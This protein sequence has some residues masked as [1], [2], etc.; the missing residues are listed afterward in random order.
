MKG[1]DISEH[2]GYID[3]EKVKKAGIDFVIIRI[4]WIGNKENHTVDEYFEEYYKKAKENNL[5]IGFYVYS[6]VKSENAMNSAINWCKNKISG[7]TYEYPIF[8]DVEDEQISNLDKNL[9]T[10]LCRLFCNSFE[11]SGIYAS[12][13]WFKNKL[14]INELLNYKIWLAQWTSSNNHSA[15]F[16]VDLWQYSSNGAVEGINGR[17]DL[18][19]CLRCDNIEDITGGEN[20][21]MKIYQNGSTVENVYADTNLTNKIGYLNKYE[22]CDCYGIF[23]NRA[24]VRYKV[25]NSSNYKIGFCK[26]I[27]GVK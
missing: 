6:Y 22:K 26:W 5:K 10:N 8:L 16:R 15:N 20:E 2:N 13:D 1:I 9:Q 25:D 14:K 18:N 27:G 24:V 12:L 4:G 19:K 11:N 3:F 21:V 7:K 23:N 17:V